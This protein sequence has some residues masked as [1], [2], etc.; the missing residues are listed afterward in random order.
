[1]T[2]PGFSRLEEP[3]PA[4]AFSGA[5]QTDTTKAWSGGTAAISTSTGARASV[6][7]LGTSV[8]WIG[9][10]GPQSGIANVYLDGAF[11][12]QI[13]TFSPNEIQT[14]VYTASGLLPAWHTL[15][16]ETTGAR[17]PAASNVLVVVDA[18]DIGGRVEDADPAIV[19]TG[20]WLKQYA[21]FASSGT[22]PSRRT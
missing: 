11:Q 19:Y 14:P 1:M 4:V 2:T 18:F 8:T 20:S 17:N 16:V 7:F 3:A 15:A 6:T 21:G 5:W 10:R 22:S 12:A 13:D 9:L